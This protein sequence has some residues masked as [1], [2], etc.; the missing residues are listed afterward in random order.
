[1]SEQVS[2]RKP[3]EVLEQLAAVI[4]ES[5]THAHQQIKYYRNTW[6]YRPPEYAQVCWGE[7]MD[8]VNQLCKPPAP[9]D[10]EWKI[11]LVAIFLNEPEDK[12]REKFGAK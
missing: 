3:H 12:V 10:E 11:K 7:M 4:P 6:G 8:L 1:M 9:L 5:Q 2:E